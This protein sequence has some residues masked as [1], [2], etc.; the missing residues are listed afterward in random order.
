VVVLTERIL[1]ALEHVK[2][3]K[4]DFNSVQSFNLLAIKRTK[5]LNKLRV[6]DQNAYLQIVKDYKIN[7]SETRAEILKSIKLES[8]PHRGK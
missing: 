5:L 6:I 1:R 8:K 3:N 7:H 4:K 2:K